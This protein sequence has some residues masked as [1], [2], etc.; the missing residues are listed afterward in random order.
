VATENNSRINEKRA[1]QP[2][3]EAVDRFLSFIKKKY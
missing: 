1:D 2:L 3:R